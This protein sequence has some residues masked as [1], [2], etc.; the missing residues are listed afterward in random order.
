MSWMSIVGR[1]AGWA[2][3]GGSE[4]LLD[5]LLEAYER[6]LAAEN[7]SDRIEAERDIARLEAAREAMDAAESDRWSA[8]SLGRYLIVV[9]F[10]IWWAA[11]MLDSIAGFESWDVLALPPIVMDL[12]VWLVPAIVVGD[13]LG[14]GIRRF[15][16]H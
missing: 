3:G 5:R 1:I 8:T 14:F 12:A 16:R 7:D 4:R 9:P 13:V 10:G 2:I 11:I 6:K 15:S